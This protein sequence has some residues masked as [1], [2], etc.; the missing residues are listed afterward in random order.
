MRVIYND[1]S[2]LNVSEIIVEGYHLLG[3]DI[4]TIDL[5]EIARIEEDYEEE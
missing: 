1:G 5:E 4:Y 2:V 3:D